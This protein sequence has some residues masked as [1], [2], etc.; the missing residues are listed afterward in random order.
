VA[1]GANVK[2]CSAM[3]GHTSATLTLDI[4]AVLFD[5]DLDAV[6]ERLDQAVDPTK[7]ELSAG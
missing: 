7:C 1:A 4:Y 2:R 3:L 5:V 6:A